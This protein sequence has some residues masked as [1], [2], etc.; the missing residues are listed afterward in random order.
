MVFQHSR[1]HETHIFSFIPTLTVHFKQILIMKIEAE[2]EIT[3]CHTCVESGGPAVPH[4]RNETK[5]R[6]IPASEPGEDAIPTAEETTSVWPYTFLITRLVARMVSFSVPASAGEPSPPPPWIDKPAS[7][8]LRFTVGWSV[9][10]R[11]PH[12]FAGLSL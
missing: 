12:G 2:N 6:A 9:I 1:I 11:R 5:Y 10:V 8:T 7:L 3:P 4:S